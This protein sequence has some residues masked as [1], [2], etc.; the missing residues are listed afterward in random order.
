MTRAFYPMQLAPR[1]TARPFHALHGPPTTNSARPAIG[2]FRSHTARVRI[3]DADLRRSCGTTRRDR[4]KPENLIEI[5][6]TL[7]LF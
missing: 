4:W 2:I 6:R 5:R 1:K 7:G 3:T